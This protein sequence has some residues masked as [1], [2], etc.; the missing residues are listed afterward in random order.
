MSA[1]VLLVAIALGQTPA[2]KPV[3]EAEKKEFIE[4]LSKLPTEGKRGF[5]EEAITKAVP[6][7]RVLLSLTEADLKRRDVYPFLVLSAQLLDRKEPREYAVAHFPSIAHP[8]LKLA[9]GLALFERGQASPEIATFLYQSLQSKEQTRTLS[10]LLGPNFKDFR[11]R[12]VSSAHDPT[13]LQLEDKTL[14]YLWKVNEGYKPGPATGLYYQAEADGK[15][16]KVA[17][18]HEYRAVNVGN[19]VVVC[20]TQLNQPDKLSF[21]V[22]RHGI[23]GPVTEIEVAKGREHNLW[24]EDM[25]LYADGDRIWFVNTLAS[26]TLFELRLVESQT[27]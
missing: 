3:T 13:V 4:L 22:I 24:S 2:D 19:R 8:V 7:S 26:N 21:F 10:G 9:W 17:S 6:Y 27:P 23:A 1:T 14:H 15:S 18:G 11:E 20:F 12:L 16:L 5:T 25:V